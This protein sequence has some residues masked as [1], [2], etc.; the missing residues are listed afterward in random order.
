MTPLTIVA[1]VMRLVHTVRH[2]QAKQIAYRI[3]R[4]FHRP[5]LDMTPGPGRPLARGTSS[6]WSTTADILAQIAFVFSAKNFPS[7]RSASRHE[8]VSSFGITGGPP[9]SDRPFVGF[10]PLEGDLYRMLA[11]T[12][13]IP[14]SPSFDMI[15]VMWPR[16]REGRFRVGGLAAS[17]T[18][19]MAV[20]R[21]AWSL[22]PANGWDGSLTCS[23]I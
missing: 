1:E 3:L 11:P 23:R 20:R 7:D 17:S 18:A 9:R 2:L 8:K 14:R 13:P 22:V 12:S 6:S 10:V 21:T 15:R 19:S 16:S 4:R 5:G